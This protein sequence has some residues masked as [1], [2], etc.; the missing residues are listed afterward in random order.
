MKKPVANATLWMAAPSSP[1]P[2]APQRSTTVNQEILRF[3][4]FFFG[5]CCL[6]VLLL[7]VFFAWRGETHWKSALWIFI[8]SASNILFYT[9]SWRS[10]RPFRFLVAQTLF[11]GILCPLVYLKTDGVLALWWP[12]YAIMAFGGAVAWG[13]QT[14]TPRWSRLVL[15]YYLVS[16]V[17]VSLW[18]PGK[19]NFYDLTVRIGLIGL[20]GLMLVQL[21]DIL[22]QSLSKDYESSLQHLRSKED[23]KELTRLKTEFF[24]NVSHEFRTPITLTLGPLEAVVHGRYGEISPE[25]RTQVG[26]MVRNQQRLLGL[27][28]QILDIAKAEAG[29][30]ELKVAPLP[31]FN[32]FVQERL[33]QFR[34]MAESRGIALK[35]SFDPLVKGMELYI[36]TEKFDKILFNLLSNALKFTKQGFVEATT[37]IRGDR[38]ILKVSDSGVGIKESELPHV[39][40]R[41][42]QADGSTTREFAGTGLGLT[43]VKEF[44]RLHGGEVSVQSRYGQGTSFEISI[45]LGKAHLPPNAIVDFVEGEESRTTASLVEAPA[46]PETASNCAELNAESER[47]RD[48]EKTTIVCAEDNPE[49]RYFLRDLLLDKYNVFVGANGKE[50]LDLAKK[51][52]PDL[53]LSDLMMP[54]MS[55]LDFCRKVREDPE[56]RPIPF[57]L[58]TAQSVSSSRIESLEEGADDYLTKPFSELELLARVRNLVSLRRNQLKLKRELEAARAIQLSL[59][60]ATPQQ[61]EGAALDYLYHPSEEL[62]GDFCDILPKGEWVYFYLA[63]VTSHGTASAQVTYLIKEIFSQS[64]TGGAADPTLVE[65]VR[66]AQKR[67]AGH[68]LQYDVALQVGRYHLKQKMLEVLRGNS[69]APLKVDSGSAAQNLSVR[70]SPALSSGAVSPEEDFHP[71]QF[72]LGAG[73]SVYF[74]TDGCYEFKPREGNFSLKRFHAILSGAPQAAEWKESLLNSLSEAQGGNNFPDDLTLLKLKVT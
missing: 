41:F 22:S 61:F 63:D 74:F 52:L 3:V 34:S 49:L 42:R 35:S 38:L 18:G 2:S 8:F 20:T 10:S 26:V 58:L 31:D 53:I 46:S 51:H 7:A 47:T 64:V 13:L 69:P 71:A 19:L 50:A 28:N 36:D 65:L 55:G 59:L 9:L 24:A 27:I 72:Q 40:E 54:V 4:A 68:G 39:F 44:V 70:P 25:L 37:E 14:S 6:F 57:V 43:L 48:P 67:Y 11:C 56:L 33:D 32:R 21:T 66:E 5:G 16:L 15:F 73:D 62:S 30:I 17:L 60:P 29:A 1:N 23:L 12:G 45:P